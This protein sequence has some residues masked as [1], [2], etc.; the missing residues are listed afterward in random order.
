M[1]PEVQVRLQL[2]R[3]LFFCHIPLSRLFL[4]S[5]FVLPSLNYLLNIEFARYKISTNWD[6]KADWANGKGG[7]SRSAIDYRQT[8]PELQPSLSIQDTTTCTTTT[9]ICGMRV[10]GLGLD[11]GSRSSSI[12]SSGYGSSGEAERAYLP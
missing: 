7:V 5:S 8:F 3:R 10:S 4:F 12:S 9:G 11:G 6:H 2:V 1:I